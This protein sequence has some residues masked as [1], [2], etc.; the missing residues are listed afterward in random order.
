MSRWNVVLSVLL[1][2]SS[3]M[4]AWYLSPRLAAAQQLGRTARVISAQKFILVDEHGVQAG[5][6]GFD[7]NGRPEITLLGPDGNVIW[8][9]ELRT[10]RIAH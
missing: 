2:F 7:K 4:F 6:F 3:G 10:E 8:S 5:I 1:G 9:T